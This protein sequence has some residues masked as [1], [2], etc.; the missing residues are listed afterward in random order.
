MNVA[1]MG[2]GLCLW[3]AGANEAQREVTGTC[4]S[5]REAAEI[6]ESRREVAGTRGGESGV[7]SG[8]W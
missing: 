8:F 5:R 1:G 2:H 7:S 4:E 3:V 6:S